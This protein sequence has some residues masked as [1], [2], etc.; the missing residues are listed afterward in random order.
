MNVE[1]GCLDTAVPCK[2]RD[3]VD[4]PVC[5]RQVRQTQVPEAVRSEARQIASQGHTGDCFGPCPDRDRLPMVAARLRKKQRT[6]FS[7]EFPTNAQISAE[8]LAGR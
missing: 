7:A 1:R 3:L 5:S 8:Q 4:V 2:G 6:T